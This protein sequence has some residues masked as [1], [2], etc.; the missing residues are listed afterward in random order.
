VTTGQHAIPEVKPMVIVDC[1]VGREFVWVHADSPL[2]HWKVDDTVVFRNSSWRVVSRT[3]ERDS[4]SLRL[5]P[6]N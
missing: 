1:P 6:L 5:G 4:L 3:E 2:A